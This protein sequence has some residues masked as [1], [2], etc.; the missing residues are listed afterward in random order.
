[1][2]RIILQ[3][4]LIC[5]SLT[6]LAQN[7]SEPLDVYLKNSQYQK[8]LDYLD[9]QEPTK[10]ILLQKAQC[11]KALQNYNKPVEILTSLT[12]EYPDDIEIKSELAVCYKLAGQTN[13]SITCYND[14]IDFDPANIY[15]K[16]QKADILYQEEKYKDALAIYKNIYEQESLSNIARR[17][18]QCFEKTQ[19]ADSAIIFYKKAWESNPDD[20]FSCGSLINLLMNIF[21]TEEGLSYS[22]TYLKRNPHDQ[23]INLLNGICLYK[24]ENYEK[25]V[26]RFT[27]CYENGDHS[28]LLNTCLG[29]SYY[30]LKDYSNALPFLEEA[31]Y[32]D[33]SNNNTL[34][35][36]ATTYKET[37]NTKKAVDLYK[38]LLDRSIPS[39]YTLYYYSKNLAEAYI[40]NKDYQDAIEAYLSALKFAGNYQKMDIYFSIA[41]IYE[42]SLKSNKNA[43]IYYRLYKKHLEEH[44][45]SLKDSSNPEEKKVSE[46][47]EKLRHLEKH[48]KSIE[49]PI[50]K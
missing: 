45:S 12:K 27:Q 40:A 19:A 26:V 35:S 4:C 48:I 10:N 39:N 43:L 37:G 5:I 3:I 6:S 7:T 13:K 47:E 2:K 42:H 20:G 21:R 31:F 44:L 33:E 32:Q 17:I 15:F 16:I 50:N 11:Y 46:A 28:M 34:S 30:K 23:Q 18:G 41:E 1:M 24:L 14:L 22:E 29:T 49:K 9:S 38:R 8:A 36:L 25:A